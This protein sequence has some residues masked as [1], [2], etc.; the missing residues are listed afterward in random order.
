MHCELQDNGRE[1]NNASHC[2]Y[3]LM[4]F[5]TNSSGNIA[6]CSAR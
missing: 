5:F 6:T 3:I 2:G 1:L 4:S